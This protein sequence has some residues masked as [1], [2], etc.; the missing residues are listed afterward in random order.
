MTP[1]LLPLSEID[2]TALPRDRTHFDPQ[3]LQELR[4][5]IATSGLRQPIEVFQMSEPRDGFRY[6]LISGHRRLTAMQE[7]CQINP[8]RPATIAAFLRQ[9]QSLTQALAE[10]VEEND[11]RAALSP[12]EQGRIAITTVQDG[13][14][15]TLDA[16]IHGLFPSA[17]PSRRSRLRSIARVVDELDGHMATPETLSL[18]QM[19]RLA[20]ALRADFADLIRHILSQH[21]R[22]GIE[23]QWQALTTTLTEAEANLNDPTPYTPGRPR[24]LL[25]IPKG[26]TVRREMT[27]KGWTLHFTGPEATGMMMEQ[28]L[29]DLERMYGAG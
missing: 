12:W 20:A 23:A 28:V 14:F 4:T 21:A 19:L 7:L 26:L 15:P 16:A 18:R 11:I 1:T 27:T 9:P 13:Y 17:N 25:R 5:S 24:R 29:H 3:A 22:E 2:A 10:M 6:A 8:N